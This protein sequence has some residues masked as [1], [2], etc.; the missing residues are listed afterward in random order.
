[1]QNTKKWQILKQPHQIIIIISAL[2]AKQQRGLKYSIG[3]VLE[4]V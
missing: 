4:S 3:F 1:M 2:F